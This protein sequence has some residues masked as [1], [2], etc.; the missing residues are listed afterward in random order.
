MGKGEKMDKVEKQ[1]KLIHFLQSKYYRS[2]EVITFIP[3]TWGMPADR[4]EVKDTSNHVCFDVEGK[5]EGDNYVITENYYQ[6]LCLPE[7]REKIEHIA[8][9]IFG[10]CRIYMEPERVYLYLDEDTYNQDKVIE[11]KN[12]AVLLGDKLWYKLCWLSKGELMLISDEVEPSKLT[13]S[14]HADIFFIDDQD[15]IV[16]QNIPD[17]VEAFNDISK[18]LDGN[19]LERLCSLVYLD[20]IIDKNIGNVGNVIQYILAKDLNKN[21]PCE[22]TKSEWEQLLNAILYDNCMST[23]QVTLFEDVTKSEKDVLQGHRAVCFT[24]LVGRCYVIFRGTYGDVEWFDNADGMLDA[25]T[26]QQKAAFRFVKRVKDNLH[27]SYLAVAGHSKGGNKAQYCAITAPKGMVD[28]GLSVDGQG[29]STAFLAKYKEQLKGLKNLELIAEQRDF[30]NCLGFYSGQ[31]EFYRG[32]RGGSKRTFYGDPLPYFHCPDAL[33]DKNDKRGKKSTSGAI[34]TMINHYITYFLSKE[35]YAPIRNK[36]AHSIV[37]L[38]MQNPMSSDE[39]IAEAIV[40]M[41]VLFL[42]IDHHSSSFQKELEEVIK[43]EVDVLLATIEP[44]SLDKNGDSLKDLV[45]SKLANRLI[46]EPIYLLYLAKFILK[47]VAFAKE[48]VSKSTKNAKVMAYLIE[49]ICSVLKLVLAKKKE[50]SV[51]YKIISGLEKFI[52]F[53]HRFMKNENLLPVGADFTIEA[54]DITAEIEEQVKEWM[55]LIST[56]IW[57]S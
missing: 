48:I 18:Q 57:K 38:M 54:N 40:N 2:F 24:D 50:K 8:T 25:D 1:E 28:Y 22:M 46:K 12:R 45:I 52:R 16:S 19:Q 17:T 13:V 43:K 47:T 42:D 5:T 34:P 23:L 32:R 39:E 37:S 31:T 35:K 29:F 3:Q 21:L 44:S 33:R 55:E 15:K 27:P 6:I 9:E 7:T 4:W 41:I 36:T 51:L 53:L 30:V 49:I 10:Q 26:V 14:L 56:E 20:R 11:F